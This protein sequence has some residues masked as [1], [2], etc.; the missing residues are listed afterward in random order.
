MTF[1]F[2]CEK[3]K[4]K[5]SMEEAPRR[6]PY[7]RAICNPCADKFYPTSL[8]MKFLRPTRHLGWRNG[9]HITTTEI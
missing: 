4:K 3:C 9:Q 2:Q 1:T 8:D 6:D 7:C 5:V